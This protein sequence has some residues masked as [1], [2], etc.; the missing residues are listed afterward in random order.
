[1]N[2]IKTVNFGN[3]IFESFIEHLTEFKPTSIK[4]YN[5]GDLYFIDDH[6]KVGSV[7]TIKLN[8]KKFFKFEID[9]ENFITLTEKEYSVIKPFKANNFNDLVKRLEFLEKFY[10]KY[11][12][13]ESIK[14]EIKEFFMYLMDFYQCIFHNDFIGDIDQDSVDKSVK[15]RLKNI[16]IFDLQEE[17]MIYKDDNGEITSFN[18]GLN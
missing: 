15:V 13:D 9:G 2:N 3:L 11:D 16:N 10:N 1:M 7:R 5:N 12:N 4:K 8:S 14:K 18:Y 6:D 17:N